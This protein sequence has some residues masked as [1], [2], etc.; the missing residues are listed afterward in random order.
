MIPSIAKVLNFLIDFITKNFELEYQDGNALVEERR[1]NLNLQIKDY[2]KPAPVCPIC[3]ESYV[4][5]IEHTFKCLFRSAVDF[6][7][8]ELAR[9]YINSKYDLYSL[10]KGKGCDPLHD[11]LVCDQN[12]LIEVADTD[13]YFCINLKIVSITRTL[14]IAQGVTES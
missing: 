8:N 5:K 9:T 12:T 14:H 7:D 3:S 10:L 2:K 6:D 11:C 1:S 13:T 4:V